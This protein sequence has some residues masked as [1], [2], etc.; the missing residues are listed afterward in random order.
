MGTS[1]PATIPVH[2]GF[3]LDGNRRW[4][5]AEGLPQLQGHLA[6]YRNLH[7]VANH[8][9]DR[10]VKF[11]SA[12]VFSTENWNRTEE[13]VNYLMDLL[14]WV[15]TKEIK[16]YVKEGLKLVFVGSQTRL[17][18]KVK[19]AIASAEAKTRNNT[20]GTVA[21]CLNYGGHTELAEGVVRLIEDG[22]SAREITPARLAQYLYHPEIPPVDFII[23]TSGEQRL[24]NFMLWRAAY[25]ELYFTPVFWPAFSVGDLDAA[26]EDYASRQRRFGG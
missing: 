20:R 26:L 4:A 18:D 12:Y 15:A 11:V 6:G 5:R 9:I 22:V 14:V 21:L 10:G 17:S 23:R 3:I 13:E 7:T 16:K 19:R 1:L 2:I 8:A 24:S 25:A